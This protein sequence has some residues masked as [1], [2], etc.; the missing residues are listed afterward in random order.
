MVPIWNRPVETRNC[1]VS[2]V[3]YTPTS[4]L[5]LVDNCSDRETE[6]M[7]EEFAE[8][9]DVRVLLLKTKVNEGF[10]KAVNRGVSRSETPLVAVVRHN[11]RVTQSWLEPLLAFAGD[12][13]S[14]GIVVPRFVDAGA[15][16]RGNGES[17]LARGMELQAADFAA[18]MMRRSLLERIGGFNEELDGGEWCLK[19]FSRR[20]YRAGFTTCAVPEGQVYRSEDVQ[21]GSLTRRAEHEKSISG[22][23]VEQWGAERRF[24]LHLP[25]E[26]DFAAFMATFPMI[27]AAARQGHRITILAHA[28]VARELLR[29]GLHQRHRHVEIV[30]LPGLMPARTVRQVLERFAEPPPLIDVQKGTPCPGFTATM[31]FAEFVQMVS[32]T[33]RDVYGRRLESALPPV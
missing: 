7:L 33:E 2:L 24:C 10:V 12:E 25:K 8:A 32:A 29:Q 5:I 13:P 31:D 30:V 6:R 23:F 18:L 14:A 28:R 22:Q 9:L 1:L 4:R 21:L 15:R 17:P 11:S 27:I 19:E 26:S 20:A 3:E 16:R